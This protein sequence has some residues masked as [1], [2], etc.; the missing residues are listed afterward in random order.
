MAGITDFVTFLFVADLETSH[1]FY[2]G[3]LGFEPVVDQGDCRIYRVTATGFLGICVRP[4]RVQDDGVIVTLVTDDVDGMHE[5]LV[6]AGAVVESEPEHSEQYRIR[7]AFYRDPD[8]HL[9]EVQSFDN[10]NWASSK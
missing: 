2:S 6:A 1:S 7:H 5:R 8:G 9:V 4:E 10:P 3:I